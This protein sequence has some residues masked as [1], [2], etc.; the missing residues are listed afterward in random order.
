MEIIILLVEDVVYVRYFYSENDNY[1]D[2]LGG[3]YF[4]LIYDLVF[5]FQFL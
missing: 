3:L 4:N 5:Y 1:N 2:G